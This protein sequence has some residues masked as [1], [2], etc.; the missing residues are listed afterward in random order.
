MKYVE[1]EEVSLE[2]LQ[3][4]KEEPW[5]FEDQ[6]EDDDALEDHYITLTLADSFEKLSLS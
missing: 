1:Y 4:T 3:N 5:I 2:A 6:S